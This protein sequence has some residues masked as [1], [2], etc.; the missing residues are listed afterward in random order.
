MDTPQKIRHGTADWFA[1]VGTIMVEGALQTE[2]PADLNVSLVERYTDGMALPGGTVQG[3]RFDVT[4]G[5]PSFRI[6]AYPDEQADLI[7]EISTA[8]AQTLNRLHSAEPRYRVTLDAFVQRGEMRVTGNITRLGGTGWV[9]STIR[10]WTAPSSRSWRQ[11]AMGPDHG[12]AP[13]LH[14]RTMLPQTGHAGQTRLQK[15]RPLVKGSCRSAW[16]FLVG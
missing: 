13:P 15:P 5:T 10:S 7:V 16:R 14:E 6:G 8:A 12:S 3:L 1:M 9:R 11:L 2:L 4:A